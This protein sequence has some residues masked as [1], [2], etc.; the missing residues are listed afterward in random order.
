MA[1]VARKGL[2]TLCAASSSHLPSAWT[3]ASRTSGTTSILLGQNF[4]RLQ[5]FSSGSCCRALA[6]T[7]I[8]LDTEEGPRFAGQRNDDDGRSDSARFDSLKG[9]ISH[10][11]L[12]A[13]TVRPFKLTHMT[14]VQ[15]AVLPLLPGLAEPFRARSPDEEQAP[16]RD[17]LV[18]AKTGTGKTL[19]FLVPAIEARL[20]AIEEHGKK[21]V[22]DAGLVS[23]KVLEARAKKLF[24]RTHVGTLII[25]P[26]RELAT[27][28][29]NEA[30]RLSEH[31]PGF[32]V[33]LFV[34]GAS[35]R[36]Q[37]RDWM[38]G[39]RDIVVTTPGR[40]RD[41]LTSEPEIVEGI[42]HT[43][44]LILDEA[45]TLLDMGF[46][47]D[48]DAIV[49]YL[50]QRPERQTFLF[51]ATVSR[52]IQQVARATLDKRH[53]FI[54]TVTEDT[55]PVHAHVPQ[56]HT[57]LPFA[58]EQ[59]PHILRLLAHDQLI[60][61]GA[62]KA[63]VF[64]PTTKMTQLYA[65]FLRELSRAVLPA[66]K[67]TRVYEIHSK[68]T[69]EAR[70]S[71]SNMFREDKSG[72]SI[73]VTS[74]VSARGVDYPNVSRVIQ[75]G[76]PGSTDQYIH[77]IGRTGRAGT[78][79]RGD[80]VLLPWEVGFVTW[81]LQEVPLKPITSNELKRQLHEL[82]EKFDADPAEFFK[83]VKM[84]AVDKRGRRVGP[85]M[86]S[87]PISPRIS[88]MGE[89]IAQLISSV[90]EEAVNE[91]FTSLLGY[92]ISRAADMRV[93]RSV[94]LEGCRNWTVEACGLP[95]APYVS[96]SFLQKIGFTNERPKQSG[97][98]QFRESKARGGMF[99]NPWEGRG[100]QRLKS[101]TRDEPIW[102][103]DDQSSDGPPR[104]RS[105]YERR[106][107]R[108]DRGQYG[109]RSYQSTYGGSRDRD[110]YKSSEGWD[111]LPQRNT[112]TDAG[113]RGYGISRR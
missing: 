40:M 15:E 62:S 34:G 88:S 110:S 76:I 20:K 84:A 67:S 90:D 73:L 109:A 77:R 101:R 70:T 46:R 9:E 80:L 5:N 59:L 42:K 102:G 43:Q 31:H 49:D 63:I 103:T 4:Y 44:T 95:T 13:I 68:R 75:V 79:G 93:Q 91:T 64:L 21:A 104:E 58:S 32:E 85:V 92:Y 52:A 99:R 2:R 71:T 17:L 94:V 60:N 97:R 30:L 38:R 6:S 55:S 39:R 74:D 87:A 19:A 57:V 18:R 1:T 48:I 69:Q 83:D 89:E 28:I 65:T 105:G 72:A 35:K 78:N 29:A 23:D 45:D 53:L 96:E 106:G 27:Q 51:S 81:Q 37:M 26:T 47:D 98:N 7:L 61:P 82:S 66:G 25:S 108:G 112:R 111:S 33:R 56:Y 3:S 107:D 54:N 41:L 8:Q 10:D 100:S 50:P 22:R 14:P 86:H 113:E 11:T 16:V 12:K 36:M 24:T